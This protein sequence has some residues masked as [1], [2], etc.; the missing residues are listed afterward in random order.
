MYFIKQ[1][2]PASALKLSSMK[3]VPVAKKGWRLL[4]IKDLG[5]LRP[6]DPNFISRFKNPIA[7]LKCKHLGLITH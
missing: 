3:L 4:V 7:G 5:F 6:H 1:G 2:S